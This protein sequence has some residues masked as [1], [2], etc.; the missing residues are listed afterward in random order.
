MKK[1]LDKKTIVFDLDE[2]LIHCNE[3]TRIPSDVVLAIKFPQGEIIEVDKYFLIK[4]I[5][6]IKG[7][8]KH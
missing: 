2:T 3:N 8:Y 5:I 4:I 1:I 7:W 6:F